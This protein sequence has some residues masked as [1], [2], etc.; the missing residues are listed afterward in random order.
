MRRDRGAPR[1]ILPLLLVAAIAGP[2]AYAYTSSNSVPATQAGAGSSTVS[3]YTASSISYALDA[4]T[5]TNIDAVTFAITP[6][7]GTVKVRLDPTGSWYDCT[8]T[9]GSVSCDTTS[10]QATVDQTTELTVVAAQ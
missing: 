2:S 4:T 7:D 5:P 6:T 1:R 10:P 8:N 9:G 3:G